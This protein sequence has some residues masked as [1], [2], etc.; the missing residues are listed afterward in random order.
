LIGLFGF[1]GLAIDLGVLAVS[2]TQSQNA[3]DVASLVGTRT[4]NNVPGIP[5]NNLPQAVTNVIGSATSNNLLNSQFTQAQITKV[6][7]GQYLYNPSSQTFGVPT[8]TDVT[9]NQSVTPP[10]GSWSAIRVT[11]NVQP[12]TF[13]MTVFGVNSMPTGAIAT[14]TY[15]P[16]DV[17]FVLDMTGSMG[18]ASN[19]NYAGSSLNP[20]N[21]IM[22]A[23]HYTSFQSALMATANLATGTGEA[24]S[25]NNFT[26]TTPGGPPIVRGF[27]CDSSNLSSPSTSVYPVTPGN[28]IMAMHNIPASAETPGN[29]SNYQPS[30]YDFTNYNAFD[31]SRVNGPTPAPPSFGTM[32]DVGTLTY[33]GDRWRRADGSI[34]TTDTTWATGAA[35]TR[36]AATAAELLG[37]TVSGTNI[38]SGGTTITTV[39]KFRDAV[40]EAN[41]YDLNIVQYRTDK[42]TTGPKDPSLYVAPLVPSAT[43]F[44]GYS[45]G[46]GYWGKTFYRWPPDPRFNT[47]ANLTSPSSTNPGFDTSGNAMCDWRR[48]FFLNNAGA[49]F[50]PQA[51]TVNQT[52]LNGGGGITLNQTTSNW[53]INYPAVLAWLKTGP[54][55]L[56][57]NLRAGRVLFYSSI[58]TDVNT[59]TGTTQQVLDKVFWKRYIDWVLGVSSQGSTALYGNADNWTA[60]ASQSIYTGTM[61]TWAGPLSTWPAVKPYMDYADSPIRPRLHFWFGP[62]SMLDFIS[63]IG[64]ND[65]MP[66]TCSQAQCWQL[67]AGMNSVIGDVESN[68]PNH[69]MGM[70]L[71]SSGYND[72][73]VPMGQNYIALQNALFYPKTLLPAINGGNTTNEERPYDVNWNSVGGDEIPNANGSTDPNAGFAYAF[74][75]LSPSSLLPSQ[76]RPTVNG[77][78][79]QGRRGVPKVVIFET[80]GVPNTYYALNSGGNWPPTLAGY[81]TYYQQAGWSSGNIGNGVE[82]CMSNAL[83][84]VQQIVKPMS[85][86][87]TGGT[88]SGMSLPNA[89]AK[90]YA[91][92][93]G[94]IFDPVA[95]PGATF[96]PTALQFLANVSYY[97]GTGPSGASAPPSW[98]IIT[99]TYTNRISTLRTCMQRIFQ[100]GV[101]VTLVE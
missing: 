100:A 7:V 47:A 88:D 2:R 36:G 61:N 10:T 59:S 58:P 67:K 16:R 80:D 89:P 30:T 56:P 85:T 66:G 62:L 71:F 19:F 22:V 33:V 77:N 28:L 31:T 46:A 97:G 92:G 55:T 98:Q 91:V 69:Y 17:A 52:L 13:F 4:L 48:H 96:R 57:P 60:G 32:T 72:I 8:W 39:D 34:N 35:S 44:I 26:V 24:I 6:Q 75:L 38:Q 79:V 3:A 1:V 37:Y 53:Q 40:W 50:N 81:N 95:S 43:R 83:G 86:A 63:V 25:R 90:V 41:G 42:G 45:M 15:K 70:V 84:I 18:Y 82:P 11:M 12:Q 101:A 87:S 54:Q 74:N 99:G 73:R 93:F 5:Y 27:Y 76:Y 68:H 21:L 78:V 65:W 49:A 9:S 14:A 23:G 20:D 94:D 64:A 51:T 29:S